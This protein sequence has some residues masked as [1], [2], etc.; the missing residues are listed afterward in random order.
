MQVDI[1]TTFPGMF[2]G[3]LNESMM[4]RARN[5]GTLRVNVHDLRDFT[6]DP[7]RSVDDTPFGGGGGMILMADPVA[8]AIESIRGD[9]EATIIIPTA[10]GRLF[11]QKV[12]DSLTTHQHLIVVCGHYTGIDERIFEYFNPMR[13]CIGEYVLTGGELPAM[14]IVDAVARRLP[15]FLG[16]DDSGRD[17]SFVIDSLGAAH[18]TRPQEWRG[19]SVPSVLVSGHHANVKE[20]REQ[21]ARQ[22]TERFR[23]DLLEDDDESTSRSTDERAS[24]RDNTAASA[25][26]DRL[27]NEEIGHG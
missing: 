12:A 5:Q 24:H 22:T 4:A 16:N 13:L 10:R 6:T 11:D 2:T 21:Q 7:H 18:Y 14:V 3:F 1:I 15:G 20:W 25:P 8:R 9:D 27:A 17:D 19:L 23:P 26:R